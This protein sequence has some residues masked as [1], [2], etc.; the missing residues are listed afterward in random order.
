M[1]L[2]T[3]GDLILALGIIVGIITFTKCNCDYLPREEKIDD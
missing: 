2:D 3:L 1:S